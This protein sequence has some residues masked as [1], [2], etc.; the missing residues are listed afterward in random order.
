MNTNP[1][2]VDYSDAKLRIL[3]EEF[4]TMQRREFT[5][6]GVCDYVLYRAMEEGRTG[7]QTLYES[8]ELKPADQERIHSILKMI[9][10]EGRITE[11]ADNMKFVKVME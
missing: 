8:N 4:I 3:V 7:V 5:F 1:I 6:R 9:T 2:P 10:D 11:T